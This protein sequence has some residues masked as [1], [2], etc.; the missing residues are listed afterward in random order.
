MN[1]LDLPGE[2][3]ATGSGKIRKKGLQM[4]GRA[5]DDPVYQWAGR[6]GPSYT[7]MADDDKAALREA[8]R[9]AGR[10]RFLR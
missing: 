7:L 3:P 10:E 9:A 2:L 1:D 8:F 5:C 6:G 4:E